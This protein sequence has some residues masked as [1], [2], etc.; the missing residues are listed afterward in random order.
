MKIVK[1][2]WGDEK[3]F[4]FNKKCTVKIL[5]VKPK[6]ILSLQ[7]HKKR[8]ELWYFLTEGYVQLGDKKKKIKKGGIVQVKKNQAHRI[9]AKNKKVNVLEIAYGDFDLKDIVRIEDAYGRAKKK[10]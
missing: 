2:P 9:F 5:S 10:K 6:G 7:K 3:H 8:K 4:I 1:K